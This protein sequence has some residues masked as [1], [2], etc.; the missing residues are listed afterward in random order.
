[1]MVRALRAAR[2]VAKRSN[3]LGSGAGVTSILYAIICA[4]PIIPISSFKL[5]STSILFTAGK[6]NLESLSFVVVASE[7]LVILSGSSLMV[8]TPPGVVTTS[9]RS[10]VFG[11]KSDMSIISLE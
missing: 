2:A 8:A 9:R 4:E 1:M 3:A 5:S 7:L 10:P 11:S 6:K